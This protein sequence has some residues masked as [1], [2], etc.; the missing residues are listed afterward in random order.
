MTSKD[1][2]NNNVAFS[3]CKFVP[4][5]LLLRSL[6]SKAP[7]PVWANIFLFFSVLFT[8]FLA[9]NVIVQKVCDVTFQTLVFLLYFFLPC[10]LIYVISDSFVCPC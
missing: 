5:D 10:N 6:M 8:I 4:F 2:L 9:S 1:Q 7:Q 3:F